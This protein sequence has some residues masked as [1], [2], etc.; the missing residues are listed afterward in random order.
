[1]IENI[2]SIP[3]YRQKINI[4]NKK[5]NDF[6]RSLAISS[7]GVTRSN[8]NGWQSKNI[9]NCE[10]MS[11]F[12]NCLDMHILAFS[13]LISIQVERKVNRLWANLNKYSNYNLNHIHPGCLISGVYYTK[14][15]ENSGAIYFNNPVGNFCGLTRFISNNPELKS[16]R[17]FPA[18]EGDLLLFPSWLDHGV[19]PNMS[20]GERISISFNVN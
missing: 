20:D 13:S 12:L 16:F 2:F 8:V 1:M 11:E 10:E 17:E 6:V 7:D 5:I 3:L 4:D 18:E 15:P 9:V 14:V 19:L